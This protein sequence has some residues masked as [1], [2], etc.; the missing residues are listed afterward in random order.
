MSFWSSVG[1]VISRAVVSS[2]SGSAS[3]PLVT[4]GGITFT[5]GEAKAALA[6]APTFLVALEAIVTGA[7]TL[8]DVETLG[9]D[10][11]AAAGMLDPELAPVFGLAAF[12][13]PLLLNGVASGAIVGDPDPE[14][15]ANEYQSRGGRGN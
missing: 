4:K 14:R 15:D 9:E 6:A 7:G 2:L 8:A 1:A 11:L 13:L 5:V 3:T 10:A 12:A